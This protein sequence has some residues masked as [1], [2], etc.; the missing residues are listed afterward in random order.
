[1]F[2]VVFTMNYE[3]PR[4]TPNNYAHIGTA[5][6]IQDAAKLMKVSGD[7]IVDE[8]MNLVD[9]AE[10]RITLYGKKMCEM[11]LPKK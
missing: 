2:H 9:C 11:Y 1:M 10:N 4:Q 3:L 7:F 5:S 8:F 6:T